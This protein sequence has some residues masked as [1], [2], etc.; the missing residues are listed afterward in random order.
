MEKF[1]AWFT[2]NVSDER[3]EE[4]S[5]FRTDVCRH[6]TVWFDRVKQLKKH[7]FIA[8]IRTIVRAANV[9]IMRNSAY[10]G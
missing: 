5:M 10:C 2:G 6:C 7:E 4:S 3:I 8:R 1:A 9:V